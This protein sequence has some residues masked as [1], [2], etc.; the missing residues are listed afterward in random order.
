MAHPV[1]FPLNSLHETKVVCMYS[2]ELKTYFRED[3]NAEQQ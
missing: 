3:D 2:T 1:V